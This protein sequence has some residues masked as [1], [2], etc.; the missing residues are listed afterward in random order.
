MDSD[1]TLQDVVLCKLCEEPVPPLY[2]EVCQINLCKACAGEHLLDGSKFHIVVP[3]KHRKSSPKISYPECQIHTTKLCELHCEKCDIPMC[4]QCV[5]SNKHKAHDVVDVLSYLNSK[6][7][8]LQADLE[9]LGNFIHPKYQEIASSFPVQK[10]ALKRNAGELISAI[11]ERGEDWHRE[12]DNIVRKLKSDIKESECKHLAFL[13]EQEV[14]IN[15][16]IS[17]IKQ[18]I[19]G[20]KKKLDS[21]DGCLISKYK[22][23]NAEFRK[24][25]PKLI[26]SLP[27]FTYQRIITKKLIEQFGSLSAWSIKTVERPNLT[28]SLE[29]ISI[30]SPL[31]QRNWDLPLKAFEED[32]YASA[33]EIEVKE[34]F[35]EDDEEEEDEEDEDEKE[36]EEKEGEKRKIYKKKK[37][38]QNRSTCT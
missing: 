14:G 11:N 18:I 34:N 35:K 32:P 36:E 24:L 5:S 17:E 9:E 29:T 25:P 12:I 6:N 38:R 31:K 27:S 3:I 33:E 23:R 1:Y 20:L 13:K 15:H 16:N 8:A 37:R 30:Q 28:D 7:K 4:V 10:A 21:N 26:I 19:V 22:S 2:C